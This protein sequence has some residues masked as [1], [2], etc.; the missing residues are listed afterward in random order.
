MFFAVCAERAHA[1]NKWHPVVRFFA[2]FILFII[3]P[4]L[5][6][7]RANKLLYL[8]S[9]ESLKFEC[10]LPPR[11]PFCL[12]QTFYGGQ[13]SLNGYPNKQTL[14]YDTHNLHYPIIIYER[15][16]MIHTNNN[17][18]PFI[19]LIFFYWSVG[20]RHFLDLFVCFTD[21]GIPIRI[22]LPNRWD[23]FIC[24]WCSEIDIGLKFVNQQT[25][26]K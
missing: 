3:F 19:R 14:R 1:W 8:N 20:D 6:N 26:Q 10:I 4:S 16:L 17:S 9:L 2:P 5:Q 21:D 12:C 18:I 24:F 7:W 15:F 22:N 13:I 25:Y 23:V 11:A